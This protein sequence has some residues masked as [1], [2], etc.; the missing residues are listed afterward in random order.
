MIED[1]APLRP[2]RTRGTALV[3]DVA[4]FTAFSAQHPPEHVI[5][6]LDA[7]L[8]DTA[9]VVSEKG[10]VV[11]SY[12]GDGFL[13]TFNT[14]VF[15][16]D[17]ETAALAAAKDLV[18]VAKA[19]GFDVRIGIA[20]GDSVTGIIGNETRQSFYSLWGRREPGIA[21]G[22]ARKISEKLHSSGR[23][24]RG[25]RRRCCGVDASWRASDQRRGRANRGFRRFVGRLVP[26]GSWAST[27][28]IY[29]ASRQMERSER[30]IALLKRG[31]DAKVG[32]VGSL[33]TWECQESAVTV[34]VRYAGC[35]RR[36]LLV[37]RVTGMG[38]V[39]L[40]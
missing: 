20:S 25:R 40:L 11:L 26:C 4:G 37:R 6:T 18:T 13:A 22:R 16:T 31:P 30:E 34:N 2:Q 35:T 23:S 38:R 1:D 17:H 14:S 10:G 12:L 9:K 33:V 15:V 39:V 8:S 28:M 5:E 24:N 21:A 19:H 7:L 3:M 29:A 36:K 27:S 32:F